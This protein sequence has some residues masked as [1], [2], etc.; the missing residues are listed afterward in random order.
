LSGAAAMYK[1]ENPEKQ[2][3]VFKLDTQSYGIDI[4]RISEMVEIKNLITTD[5]A[6]EFASGMIEIRGYLI[7]V[8][9]LR[10]RFHL[11]RPLNNKD[12]RILVVDTRGNELGIVVDSVTELII[13]Q[14]SCVE[15]IDCLFIGERL[16]HLLGVVRLKDRPVILLDV[17][18]ILSKVDQAI[19]N[20]SSRKVLC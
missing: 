1:A 7:P 13:V 8:V 3:V 15:P 17:D 2:I 9:D 6:P 19:L 12:N 5:A 16:E 18:T 10:K 4:T 14:E 11:N 20:K